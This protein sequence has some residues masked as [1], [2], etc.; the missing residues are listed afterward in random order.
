MGQKLEVYVKSSQFYC[1]SLIYTTC[2]AN[3]KFCPPPCPARRNATGD[4]PSRRHRYSLSCFRFINFHSIDKYACPS[5]TR[6][7][8]YAGR[9]ACCPLVNHVEYAP[10]AH[11]QTDWRTDGRK[12]ETLCF[13]LDA[14][15][16]ILSFGVV[17]VTTLL[18]SITSVLY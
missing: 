11:R 14:V 3:S 15:G 16:R 7:K 13:L 4:H 18:N 12:T 17:E 5:N 10:S 2:E 1:S 6:T 8:M 9:V